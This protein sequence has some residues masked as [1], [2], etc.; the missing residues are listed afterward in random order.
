MSH[1][2]QSN[3]Y[4]VNLE[5][6]VAHAP[7]NARTAFIRRTYMHLTGAI[8]ALIGLE[9][10]LFQ[11]VP[12][13]TMKG[14]VATMTG[15]YGWLL[16]LVAF[17]AVS[18]VARSWANSGSSAPLQYA[19]LALYISAWGVMLLPI[20]WICIVLLDDPKLPVTA[21]VITGVAFA[22]L[23]VVAF[24]TKADLSNWGRYLMMFGFVA[25]GVIVAGIVFGFSLGLWFSALM[26][27][28]MCGY[29]LYDT[30]NVIHHFGVDQ[31]VAA[32]LVLFADV[33][34]L[35]FYVLQIM[36]SFRR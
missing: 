20:L 26:V 5:N 18:W 29:I 6:V 4:A 17:M 30:S 10:V 11:V 32:S 36:M 19:G 7:E 23:T 13:E 8:L 33:V 15:G 16:V 12:E 22:G 21:A 25:M 9:Y 34:M 27:A 1:I 24:V 14:L 31:H 2:D 28:L 35:F 3:P